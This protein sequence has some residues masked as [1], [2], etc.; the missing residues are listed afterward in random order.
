M[1]LDRQAP[2]PLYFQLA[3]FLA[4][5]IDSG[6]WRPGDQ[7]PTE[8]ELC[9]TYGVSRATVVRAMSELVAA[10]R[11]ERVQGKGTFV[12]GR[13]FTHGPLV[14]KSFSEEMEERGLEPV[15]RVL[16]LTEE[17][18]PPAVRVPL[19]LEEG[20]RVVR[21]RRLRL[22]GQETMGIQEAWLPASLVPGLTQYRELL[23]GS[24]Y[25][26]LEARYGLR[27]RRAVET[28]EPAILDRE[29]AEILGVGGTR[30]AFLVERT[31]YDAQERPVEYV[32]SKMRGDRF[33]YTMELRRR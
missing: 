20:E 14:L 3:A 31:S 32:R 13:K 23:D 18:A 22:A 10:G 28:F 33:R 7:I 27:V 24:L 30:L 11:L 16:S 25:R 21:L 4:S 26:L 2:S 17:P 19:A 5:R 8:L 6:E 29:E 1:V 12:S 9:R 15:A